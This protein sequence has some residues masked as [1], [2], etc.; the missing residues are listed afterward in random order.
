MITCVNNQGD[1]F[2][3]CLCFAFFPKMNY[4]LKHKPIKWTL[5]SRNY[6]RKQ[7]DKFFECLKCTN[8]EH[9]GAIRKLVVTHFDVLALIYP[10][11]IKTLEHHKKPKC[12]CHNLQ[13]DECWFVGINTTV[14]NSTSLNRMVLRTSDYIPA[15]YL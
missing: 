7:A 10:E 6:V 4:V 12:S 9:A 15:L 3:E 5:H 1:E 13:L 8:K 11:K 14:D 2:D